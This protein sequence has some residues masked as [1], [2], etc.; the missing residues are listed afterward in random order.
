VGQYQ[1]PDLAAPGAET[2]A[3]YTAA[4]LQQA[5][6]IPGNHVTVLT[7]EQATLG[8]CKQGF[9]WLQQNAVSGRDTVYVYLAGAA[10]LA[11]DRPGLR[12]PGG[13]GYALFPFDARLESTAE[14]A[15]YGA[16]VADWLGAVHAQTVVL[17]VD[18][19]H[20]SAMDLPLATDA[21]RGLALIA[22]CGSAQ[23]AR[24]R[25][26]QQAGLFP[27]L[28]AAGLKGTADRNRDGKVTLTELKAYLDLELGRSTMG[29]QIPDVRGGFG[30]AAPEIEFATPR[31]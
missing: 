2:D 15:I 14:T 28:L 29:A 19:N 30:G 10:M 20:A 1:Q 31:R 8:M 21:G 22:A 23:Q 16:D 4:I 27:E 5:A 25:P 3:R 24:T 9:K 13:S 18:T 11:P 6:G 17:I 7:E 26:G 12:H